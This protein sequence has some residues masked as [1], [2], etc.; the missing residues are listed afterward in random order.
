MDFEYVGFVLDFVNE[1]KVGWIGK[2]GF[3]WIWEGKN[4]ELNVFNLKLVLN[5]KII[6]GFFFFWWKERKMI[7]IVSEFIGFIFYLFFW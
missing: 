4:Y 1:F 7:M 5:I 3:G 2:R 6:V